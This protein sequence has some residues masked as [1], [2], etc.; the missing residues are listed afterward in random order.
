LQVKR[1]NQQQDLAEDYNEKIRAKYDQNSTDRLK[2]RIIYNDLCNRYA[3]KELQKDRNYA[4]FYRDVQ[5]QQTNLQE[6]HKEKVLSPQEKRTYFLDTII[7]KN[8]IQKDQK[9]EATE[10]EKQSKFN[11]NLSEM[12][13]TNKQKIGV[14]EYKKTLNSEER[15]LKDEQR[16]KELNDYN[17]FLNLEQQKKKTIQNQYKLDLIRQTQEQKKMKSVS[18][19]MSPLEKRLN[20]GDLQAFKTYD[21]SLHSMIPGWSPQ[22]GGMPVEKTLRIKTE[23]DVKD[24]KTTGFSLC[25]PKLVNDYKGK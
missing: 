25:S 8:I 9:V 19:S 22:I 20:Y 6:L 2:N 12:A 13:F 3:N 7:E 16:L 5:N 21:P 4:N 18:V 23:P 24:F 10:L 1:A 17:E 11:R 14:E 15:R